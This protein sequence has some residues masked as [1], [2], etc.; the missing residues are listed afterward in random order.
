MNAETIKD[1]LVSPWL[2]LMKPDTRNFDLCS[3]WRHRKCHKNSGLA[4]RLRGA[5][6][7]LRVY[8]AKIASGLAFQFLLASQRTGATVQ[9]SV[10]WLRSSCG[11]RWCGRGATLAGKPPG[12][13]VIIPARKAF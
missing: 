2:A 9:D 7:L 8:L 4:V 11:G 10:D 1:F 13:C 5:G 6:P 3:C 12:L